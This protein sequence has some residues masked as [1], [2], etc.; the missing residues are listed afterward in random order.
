MRITFVLPYAGLAGGV[1]VVAE[2]AQRLS[3]RGHVVNLI[4][5]RYRWPSRRMR[6]AKAVERTLRNALGHRE[7]SHL[8]GIGVPHTTIGHAPPVTD[9]DVPDADVIVATWWETAEWVSAMS[10]SKGAKVYFVQHYEV[11]DGQPIDRVEA[12]WTLPMH[13]IAVAQW[14][15]DIAAKKYDDR[16]VSV[17]PNAVDGELFCSPTRGP[18]KAPTVGM[19]YSTRHYKGGDICILAY[20]EAR[21]TIPELKLKAFG[22]VPISADLPLPP[23]AEYFR[24][25]AQNELRT[26]YGGCD[27][28]LFASRSEGYGL[29]LLEAM[30]CRTP[31]IATPAGAAP[32]LMN[33]GGGLLVSHEEPAAMAEAIRAIA[34]LPEDEWKTMSGRAR[35]AATRYSWDDATGMFEKALARAVDLE[36][37]GESV[38]EDEARRAV[39]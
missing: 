38:G 28:W 19:M 25:P 2:Y 5:T 34:A 17:V 3:A 20:E 13:K 31:V 32:E 1:R 12:T 30:A 29:P 18:Q 10:A 11:H 23:G 6:F 35:E 36:A 9:A 24:S 7:P 16:D 4:S 21:K 37:A 8:N 33:A 22:A 39:A 14:L 26:I 15:A 27:A